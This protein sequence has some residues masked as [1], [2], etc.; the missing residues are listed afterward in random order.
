M[1]ALLSLALLLPGAAFACAMPAHVAPDEPKLVVDIG[2]GAQLEALFKTI[3]AQGATVLGGPSLLPA[4]VP[5][6]A[7]V[8]PPTSVIPEV[9]APVVPQS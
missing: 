9:A 5:D 4:P 1:R 6:P 3:E 2:P 7:P 8:T